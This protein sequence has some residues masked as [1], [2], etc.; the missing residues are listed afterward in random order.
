MSIRA[1]AWLAAPRR[2]GLR[3]RGSPLLSGG[4]VGD[5]VIGR[6][7]TGGLGHPCYARRATLAHMDDAA[8]RD[9]SGDGTAWRPPAP[10]VEAAAPWPLADV[11]D[12]LRRGPLGAAR[13]ARPPRRDGARTGWARSSGSWPVARSPSRS[14]G[15]RPTPIRIGHRRARPV[16]AAARAVRPDRSS[17]WTR[18]DRRWR[19]L[20]PERPRAARTPPEARRADRRRRWRTAFIVGHLEDHVA[21]LEAILRTPARRI[22]DAGACSS[23]TRSRSGSSPATWPAAAS[24]GLGALRL[25]WVPLALLGLAGP[26]R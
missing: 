12:D 21:Q 23:S 4:A 24:S 16:A 7:A 18:F 19:T 5:G 22:A 25:R 6:V 1:P 13:G 26:G 14:G 11:F 15:S 2:D 9:C 8:R 17:A 10:A 3:H 20:T